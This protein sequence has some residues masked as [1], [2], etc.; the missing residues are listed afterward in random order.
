MKVILAPDSFRGCMGSCEVCSHLALG[1][2][3]G[4]PDARVISF[5]M[6]DGGEGSLDVLS[7]MLSAQSHRAHITGPTGKRVVA[8][9]DLAGRTGMIEM[10]R[11]SGWSALQGDEEMDIMRTTSRG[12]GELMRKCLKMGAR[13]LL[14]CAGGTVTVDGGTGALRALGYTFL[15]GSGNHVGEGGGSLSSLRRI[16]RSRSANELDDVTIRVLADVD[17]PP[18]GQRGAAQMFAPQKGASR[19]EVEA[20][21]RG[22]ANWVD[23]LEKHTEN[24]LADLPCG[25]AAGGVSLGLH[26]L[27]GAELVMGAKWILEKGGFLNLARD[28]D[29][30]ITGEGSLDDQSLGGKV[31]VAVLEAGRSLSVPVAALCGRVRTDNDPG[32]CVTLGREI[33]DTDPIQSAIWLREAARRVT[34]EFLRSGGCRHSPRI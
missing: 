5:P 20:L 10:S 29:L 23:V 33:D 11:A 25:G 6:A 3:D 8:S 28:A 19:S 16:C 2:R 7:A 18:L 1:I 27:V 26:A 34:E 15:D 14:V 24:R 32:F 31:T 30:I 22:M 13:E 17:S 9:F 12:T 21:E 4:C